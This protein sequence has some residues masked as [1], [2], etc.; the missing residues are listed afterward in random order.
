MCLCLRVLNYTYIYIFYASEY[1]ITVSFGAPNLGTFF[2]SMKN[3]SIMRSK[4]EMIGKNGES[5]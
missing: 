4:T 1:G 2:P 3:S 5:A